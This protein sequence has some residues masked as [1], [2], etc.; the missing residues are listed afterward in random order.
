VGVLNVTPDSF[1][2]GGAHADVD[3]AVRWGLEMLAAGADIIDV[4]GEST[5][6]GGA[7]RVDAQT[8]IGRVVP[9]VRELRRRSDGLLSIDTTK[10]AVAEAAL[11]AGADLVNDVSALRF[12]PA[13]GALVARWDVP[14]VLM[15]SRGDFDT[16]HAPPGYA[17]LGAEV[18]AELRQAL[19][20]AARH[21][22]RAER[23]I[24]DPGIGFAKDAQ[25]SLEALRR[26][27]E[28]AAL[29]RP[30]LVGPSRKSFI[31]KTLD[32]PVGER[33]F[34]TAGAVAAAVLAGAHLVRVH[35]VAPMVDVVRVCD[36]LRRAA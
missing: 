31:G 25:H 7:T 1:S 2:D 19:E 10:A 33:L 26:L 11:S 16:L 8:E 20:R 21:G 30:I 34:G 32:R 29:G 18:V 5:R 6:P 27:D 12:D 35:D 36:A 3:S 24:V 15:H 14:V 9:V 28:L 13:M 4:G 22:I 17:D 23:T